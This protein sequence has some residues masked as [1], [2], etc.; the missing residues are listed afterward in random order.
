[1]QDPVNPAAATSPSSRSNLGAHHAYQEGYSALS[2][3][4]EHNK[5]LREATGGKVVG[6]GRLSQR[7]RNAVETAQGKE[8]DSAADLGQAR[9][10]VQLTENRMQALILEIAAASKQAQGAHD[11]F[12]A[13]EHEIRVRDLEKMSRKT[14]RRI[15]QLKAEQARDLARVK[16]LLAFTGKAFKFA[17]KIMSK[18]LEAVGEIVE[19][20]GSAYGTSGGDGAEVSHLKAEL[21]ELTKEIEAERDSLLQTKLR[22]ASFDFEAGTLIVAAKIVLLKGEVESRKDQYGQLAQRTGAAVAPRLGG[23]NRVGN[24][25]RFIPYLEA[26]LAATAQVDSAR[27]RVNDDPTQI[28]DPADAFYARWML[29]TLPGIADAVDALRQHCEAEL[30][31]G[32]AVMGLLDPAP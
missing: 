23:N 32:R 20:I 6:E 15:D 12:A 14:G 21:A 29:A 22:A 9:G 18:P 7:E 5:L 11:N 2:S 13:V 10:D 16:G 19:G 27:L 8:S 1:M 31:A 25:V 26:V 3:L 24:R 28:S 30:S 4:K 17:S